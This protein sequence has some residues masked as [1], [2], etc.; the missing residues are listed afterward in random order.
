ESFEKG[1]GFLKVISCLV[2]LTE[3]HIAVCTVPVK[4]R[5][6]WMLDYSRS[7]NLYCSFVV[8]TVAFEG[9]YQFIKL[10]SGFGHFFISSYF[11]LWIRSTGFDTWNVAPPE[12]RMGLVR[13]VVI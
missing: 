8:A 10:G 5:V 12:G 2:Q 4:S 3:V 6:V 13:M 7:E 9:S 1:C 11:G